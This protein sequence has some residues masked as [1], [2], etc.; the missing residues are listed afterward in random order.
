MKAIDTNILVRFLV[1][2]DPGQT[3]SVNALF[4]NAQ[5]T[6]E[7]LFVSLS[8]L[9]DTMW[10]LARAYRSPREEII[11][12]VEHLLALSML[13]VEARDRVQRLCHIARRSKQDLADILIGLTAQ[14]LGCETTLTFDK[15]AAQSD[16]FTQLR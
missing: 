11:A 8:V 7:P 10:V 12:T 13:Q 3:P 1:G 4:S 16:M 2:D 6:G 14:D 15:V 9:V 5:Q